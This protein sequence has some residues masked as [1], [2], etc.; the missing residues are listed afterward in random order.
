MLAITVLPA[1]LLGVGGL[2]FWV[3]ACFFRERTK[4]NPAWGGG[5]GKNC[6][7]Q[8]SLEETEG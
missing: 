7:E 6:G 4:N 2:R 8:I 5:G 3:F 1:G